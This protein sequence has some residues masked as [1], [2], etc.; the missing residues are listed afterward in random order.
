MKKVLI[1]APIDSSAFAACLLLRTHAIPGIEIAGVL[2]RGI[3]FDRAMKEWRRDGTR[4]LKK[5]WTNHILRGRKKVGS[6]TYPTARQQ[7]DKLGYTREGLAQLCKQNNIPYLRCDDINS[8]P[9]V[10][11]VKSLDPTLTVF[12]GGGLIR[13]PL[14]KACGEGVLNCHMGPLPRYRGMDVVEWPF[15][16][17]SYSARTAV[18]VHFMDQGLDTGP[19]IEVA[20]IPRA[21]CQ[22]ITDLRSAAEGL[23]VEAL[24][25]AVVA[26]RDGTLKSKPQSVNEGRQYFVLHPTLTQ[27][28]NKRALIALSNAQK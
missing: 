20:D 24:L 18:T 17:E 6:F 25:R 10:D 28:A 27:I 13:E 23:K 12:A 7:L 4:L 11:F 3:T 26:H 21:G 19:I 8:D 14:I 22:T 2:V 15:L 5:I 16:E 9:A 1:I